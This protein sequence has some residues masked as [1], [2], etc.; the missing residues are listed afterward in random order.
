MLLVAYAM[1]QIRFLTKDGLKIMRVH[2][3]QAAVCLAEA[4]A[5]CIF[6]AGLVCLCIQSQEQMMLL[7]P[8]PWAVALPL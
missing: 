6:H 5:A 7:L 2:S 1:Q 4:H 8:A 3:T